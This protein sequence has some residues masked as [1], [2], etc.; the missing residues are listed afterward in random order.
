MITLVVELKKFAALLEPEPEAAPG[1]PEP[2]E[3]VE[4]GVLTVETWAAV[5]VPLGVGV[6]LI[7]GVKLE[8][9]NEDGV[10]T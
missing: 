2:D 9:F 6:I 8:E 10:V 3:G 5:I 7:V 4:L 1:T